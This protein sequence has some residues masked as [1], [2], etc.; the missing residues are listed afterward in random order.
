[1]IGYERGI[2]ERLSCSQASKHNLWKGYYYTG[3]F[4][5]TLS[6]TLQIIVFLCFTPCPNLFVNKVVEQPS[7][8]LLCYQSQS[9]SDAETYKTDT[10]SAVKC[11]LLFSTSAARQGEGQVTVTAGSLPMAVCWIQAVVGKMGRLSS[12]IRIN[13]SDIKKIQVKSDSVHKQRA[14]LPLGPKLFSLKL[15]TSSVNFFSWKDKLENPSVSTNCSFVCVDTRW[16][17]GRGDSCLVQ[18]SLMDLGAFL[19]EPKQQS[20]CTRLPLAVQGCSRARRLDVNATWLDSRWFR[21]R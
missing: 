9:I 6:L 16:L 13:F 14:F 18:A 19:E 15:N 7:L 11:N 2:L 17:P 1:M 3:T 4:V 10:G 12:S 21:D 8:S 20:I 5:K